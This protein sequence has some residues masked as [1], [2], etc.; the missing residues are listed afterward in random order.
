MATPHT[1]ALPGVHVRTVEPHG[2]DAW[3]ALPVAP[4]DDALATRIRAGWASGAGGPETTFVLERDGTPVGRVVYLA[5]PAAST[6]P[7]FFEAKLLGFALDWT[8]TDAVPLGTRLVQD[9]IAAL[10][11]RVRAVDAL[12]N[13]KFQEGAEVR[14]RIFEAA[15]LPLFQEK[16]GFEWRRDD[17][18]VAR[19]DDRRLSFRSL[20]EVGEDLLAEVMDRT[21]AGTLDRQDRYYADLVGPGAWGREMLAYATPQDRPD[22]LLAFDAS[23]E[24][25][26]H[27]L[28]G[29]FDAD[30]RGTI[31]HVGVVPEARGRGYIHELLAEITEHA[32]RRG[33]TSVLSDCDTLNP[34]MADAMERAGHRSV[35]TPWHSWHFRLER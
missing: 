32:R 21:T 1:P 23:G 8:G 17:A 29:E 7:H 10:P 22:W 26:G 3:L 16:E 5:E 4:P 6:L 14:R 30:G 31:I 18:P 24:A 28:L 11:A 15:G 2:L 20:D 12:A 13:P 9:S 35:N 25:V 34:P 33:F 27:V 19:L